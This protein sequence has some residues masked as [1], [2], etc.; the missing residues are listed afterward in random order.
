MSQQYFRSVGHL[1]GGW[2]RGRTG[3]EDFGKPDRAG[4][5]DVRQVRVPPPAAL[6]RGFD[7]VELDLPRVPVP[8][9]VRVSKR[10]QP[11]HC[12]PEPRARTRPP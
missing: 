8:A 12:D 1:C 6:G 10:D 9:V 3:D 5:T 11:G 2:G 7:D 4:S